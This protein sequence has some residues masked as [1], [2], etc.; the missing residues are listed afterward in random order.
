MP[1]IE[2][3]HVVKGSQKWIKKLVNEKP[4]LITSLIRT[5]LNL[6]DNDTKGPQSID[7]WKG[8][9]SLARTLD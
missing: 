2:Q 6:P 9:L 5:H 4:D 1:R 3:G 7:E 8:A